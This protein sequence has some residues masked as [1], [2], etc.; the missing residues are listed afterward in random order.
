M[1]SQGKKYSK[2]ERQKYN[3]KL[4]VDRKRQEKKEHNKVVRNILKVKFFYRLKRE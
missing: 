2:K 4:K 3:E 1:K